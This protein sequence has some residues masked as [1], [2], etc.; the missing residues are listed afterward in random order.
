MIVT[1][2]IQQIKQ[3]IRGLALKNHSEANYKFV[4]K[5]WISLKDLSA[6]SRV[7][8]TKRFSR[9][10]DPIIMIGPKA[11]RVLFLSPH[12]DD[13]VISSGGTLLHLIR[14]G[15]EVKVVYLTSGSIKTYQDEENK[16]LS[17]AVYTL[18]EES[19]RVSK[20]LG[21]SLEFWR[22]NSFDNRE[23][24]IGNEIVK[25]IKEIFVKLKPDAVFMPFIADDHDDHRRCVQLFYEAFKDMKDVDFEV[26]AFQVYS[27][28][29]PNIVVD[30]TDVIDEKIRLINY[31]ESIK[32]SRDW[33]HYA[34]GLN[35]FNSRFLKTNRPHYAESFFVVPAKEYIELCSIYFKNPDDNIYYYNSNR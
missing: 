5:D 26:W 19:K 21:T 10:L 3:F 12:P 29:L 1:Y 13:D 17:E 15:C 20:E 34:K 11:R 33:G 35:A 16:V 22:F 31:W 24:K 28:V 2:M 18:E 30:I 27:T 25:R 23:I 9:N 4:L 14:D 6:I 8:E 7:L 32:K